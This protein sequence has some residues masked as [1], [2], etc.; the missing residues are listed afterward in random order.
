L[1]EVKRS[2]P[3]RALPEGYQ[4]VLH[5]RL[6]EGRRLLWLNVAALIPLALAVLL[7]DLWWT[8]FAGARAPAP[9]EPLNLPWWTSIAALIVLPLHE[10]VHG[11][12][13]ALLGHRPRYG[14]K[15]EAGVLF[16]TA[17]GAL[18]RRSEFL[19]IALAPLVVISLM[20]M[21][22]Q[23]VVY[24]EIGRI[25]AYAVAINAGG[26]IGDLWTVWLVS[27]FPSQAL[28]RDEEDSFR[29]FL[30]AAIDR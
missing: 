28:V 26:A 21:A 16:A 11:G 1:A 8:A 7:L 14:I 12:A 9:A 20:G 18:F 13:I 24:P 29:V 25:I 5:Y 30:P 19:V 3:L 22:L 10:L 23:L 6:T 4:E 15:L 2:G 27:R 17:D